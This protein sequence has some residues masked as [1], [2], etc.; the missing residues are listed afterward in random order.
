M[1]NSG[2]DPGTMNLILGP[3]LVCFA[4]PLLPSTAES[5]RGKSAAKIRKYE[6]IQVQ[7]LESSSSERTTMQR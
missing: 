5:G 4:P 7:G 3:L 2:R 1:L 6:K